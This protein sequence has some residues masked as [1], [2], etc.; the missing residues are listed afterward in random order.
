MSSFGDDRILIERFVE[1]PRHIEIQ[2]S[3]RSGGFGRGTSRSILVLIAARMRGLA[4]AA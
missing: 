2:V 4:G 1:R 3:W